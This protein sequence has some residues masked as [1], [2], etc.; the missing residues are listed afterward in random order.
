MIR[1]KQ[2]FDARF[3]RERKQASAFQ[4]KHCSSHPGESYRSGKVPGM[5]D[6]STLPHKAIEVP[7]S[8]Q[9]SYIKAASWIIQAWCRGAARRVP[10]L[11]YMVCVKIWQI[12]NEALNWAYEWTTGKFI[13][14]EIPEEV[15]KLVDKTKQWAISMAELI[16]YGFQ[17]W[18]KN[19]ICSLESGHIMMLVDD[20][21]VLS[22]LVLFQMIEEHL[23]P[24][25]HIEMTTASCAWNC[26][27]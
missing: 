22:L 13:S 14:S 18:L 6:N 10:N 26:F 8:Y 23:I 16:L 3:L 2:V 21:R 20:D 1:N 11:N 15:E 24:R 4:N 9:C 27:H 25:W 7:H 12:L 5:T 19:E 17:N